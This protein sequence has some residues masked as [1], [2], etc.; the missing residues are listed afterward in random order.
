VA[1]AWKARCASAV[2]PLRSRP[3]ASSKARWAAGFTGVAKT[4]AWRVAGAAAPDDDGP[5]ASRIAP[6]GCDTVEQPAATAASA[7]A[8]A[9][10]P[11]LADRIDHSQADF[12]LAVAHRPHLAQR[13]EAA[14]DPLVVDARGSAMG[15]GL[16]ELGGLLLE[17][18]CLFLEQHVVLLELGLGEVLRPLGRHQRLAEVAVDR[19]D[20]VGGGG[21]HVGHAVGGSELVGLQRLFHPLLLQAQL[22]LQRLDEL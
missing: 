16:V 9:T 19:G 13:I 5:I 20:L 10:R 7:S 17:R 4:G 1:S 2:R 21:G 15:V 12:G 11:R 6:S 8:A 3:L 22:A 18:E 14:L